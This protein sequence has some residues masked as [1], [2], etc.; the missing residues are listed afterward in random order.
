MDGNTATLPLTRSFFPELAQTSLCNSEQFVLQSTGRHQSHKVS[1]EDLI[2][3]RLWMKSGNCTFKAL[4]SNVCIRGDQA[5]SKRDTSD[6]VKMTKNQRI[7]L[8]SLLPV[9]VNKIENYFFLVVSEQ[10]TKINL[11]ISTNMP[12]PS[13][14]TYEIKPQT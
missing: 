4:L 14:Q 7:L 5:F 13:L 11:C 9:K 1:L 12:V 8:T 6:S 3:Q 10:Q 2:I